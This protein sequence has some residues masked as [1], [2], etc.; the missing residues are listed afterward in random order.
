MSPSSE[1]SCRFWSEGLPS[2]QPFPLLYSDGSSRSA[3]RR[4]VLEVF[5]AA[6]QDE[7]EL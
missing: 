5:P 7:D 1:N 4:L 6:D 2:F 3:G